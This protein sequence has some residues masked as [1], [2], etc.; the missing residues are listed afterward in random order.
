[1]LYFK[2]QFRLVSYFLSPSRL[3][4]HSCWMHTFLL[5]YRKCFLRN[6]TSLLQYLP[7]DHLHY[8]LSCPPPSW[9]GVVGLLVWHSFHLNDFSHDFC[10]GFCAKGTVP[11]HRGKKFSSNPL[12]LLGI[13]FNCHWDHFN[14][15]DDPVCQRHRGD[16][17]YPTISSNV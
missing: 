10:T 13:T 6:C 9:M 12:G 14:C 16:M 2:T 8:F 15:L 17:Y 7:Q 3:P 1:M 4:S 5:T 11:F